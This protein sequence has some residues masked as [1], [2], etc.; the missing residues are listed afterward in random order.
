MEKIRSTAKALPEGQPVTTKAF[1]A[2]G[3]RSSVDQ[4]L[5]RLVK[6]GILTRPARGMYVRPKNNS[7]VGPVP[8]SPLQAAQAVAEKVGFQVQV[9]GAEAARHMGFSTHVPMKSIFLTNG[10]SRRFQLGSVKVQ[11]KR[12]SPRKLALAGRPAGIA[13]TALW[14]LGKERTNPESIEQIR[15]RIPEK[16]FNALC[17]ETPSMPGWM[18]SALLHYMKKKIHAQLPQPRPER[19]N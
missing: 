11:L 2:F 18:S 3:S 9:Q 13:L 17:E 19:A 7:Y 10:P 5:C 4:A 12:V 16:E 8:P 15:S 6:A 1:L 14:Y